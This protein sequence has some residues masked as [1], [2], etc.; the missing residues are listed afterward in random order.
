M[1][2]YFGSFFIALSFYALFAFT[3]FYFFF[4]EKIIIK[5]PN[6]EQTISLKHIELKNMFYRLVKVKK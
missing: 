5:K 6:L 2:R 4:N 3:V 1:N